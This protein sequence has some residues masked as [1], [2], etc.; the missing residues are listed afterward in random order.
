LIGLDQGKGKKSNI[1]FLLLVTAI[2]VQGDPYQPFAEKP[3]Q[4]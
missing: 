1:D 4:L 3:K 2:D